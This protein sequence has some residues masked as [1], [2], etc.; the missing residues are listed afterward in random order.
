MPFSHDSSYTIGW[1]HRTCQDYAL[2]AERPD[3]AIAVLCD[4]CSS[5]AFSDVGARLLSHCLAVNLKDE[6]QYYASLQASLSQAEAVR[7]SMGLPI[8]ALDATLL[9]ARAYSTG[10]IIARC[11][12]DGMVVMGRHDGSMEVHAVSYPSGYPNYPIYRL[13]PERQNDEFGN[14]VDFTACVETWIVSA[15]GVITNYVQAESQEPV[16]IYF[17]NFKVHSFVA[18]LSDGA[19]TIRR[20]CDLPSDCVSAPEAATKLLSF[21]STN[22]SFV[23][24]RMK[25]FRDRCKKDDLIFSDDISMAAIAAQ[26]TVQ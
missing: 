25:A 8:E 6:R 21:K 13:Q 23:E 7:Q 14:L 3:G 4:G 16:N 18:L 10:M 22:G 2:T 15:S 11:Y 5:A 17:G 20:S 19:R 12:G 26:P 9:V 1:S 24:R